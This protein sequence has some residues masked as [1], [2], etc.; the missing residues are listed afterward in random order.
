MKKK[1]LPVILIAL[2]VLILF[3]LVLS[4]CCLH[5]EWEPATCETPRT[6]TACGK[7]K[8]EALGHAWLDATTEEPMTCSVCGATTGKRIITDPRF[9]TA[10]T[11]D[12][13]GNWA[14]NV[15]IP[16][17]YFGFDDLE[18][19][20]QVRLLI[21][22]HNDG[23]MGME[24]TATNNEAFSAAF[25]AYLY[26][27]LYAEF[28]GEDMDQ[29][30]VE[31]AIVAAYGMTA[32]QY[33]ATVMDGLDFASVISMLNSTTGVYY[34]ENGRFFSGIS[35]S[36]EMEATAYTLDGDTLVLQNDFTG[37]SEEP[38]PFERVTD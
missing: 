7:T 33:V 36:S 21:Q 19:S 32:D 16:G 6:C 2:C 29:A 27:A 20:L 4:S 34:V 38:L 1:I 25:E 15:S 23:S 22:L 30:A 10:A 14:A 8:G 17:S 31:D 37:L 24:F 26:D 18:E 13:Q 9:T 12:L 28:S 3:G 5:K 11:A 35:W